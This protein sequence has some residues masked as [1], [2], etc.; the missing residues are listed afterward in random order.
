MRKLKITGGLNWNL[1]EPIDKRSLFR[2]IQY[3]CLS[4][5]LLS[6]AAE[7]ETSLPDLTQTDPKGNFARGGKSYCGPVAISN[8]LMWLYR[9]ELN[10]SGASQYDLVNQLAS[11]KYMNTDPVKGTGPNGVMR[12][13]KQFLKDRGLSDT[14]YS[15]Q[16]QGWRSHRSEFS[17][18]VKEPQLKWI[19]ETLA[20][21]GAVWFNLGWYR[22]DEEND[23]YERIGGHWVTAIE[24]GRTPEGQPD[25][26]IVVI[27]DPAPRAG[28]E[29]TRQYVKMISLENGELI[30]KTRHLPR[31]A[32]GLFQMAGEMCIK[33]SADCAILDGAVAL[34]FK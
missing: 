10:R 34:R 8:S 26:E 1:N 23:S 18:G 7:N 16:F 21:G 15:M 3:L 4:L 32:T 29:A 24:A 9:E 25:P 27:H 11:E 31:P 17:S 22:K 30:G 12:G 13:V 20:S 5:A 2:G 33:S 19:R 6:I 28:Q 14:D